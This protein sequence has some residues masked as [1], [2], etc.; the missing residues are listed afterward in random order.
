M[1]READLL[2]AHAAADAV[3]VEARRWTGRHLHR[4]SKPDGTL[5]TEADVAMEAVA[6]SVLSRFSR[7][8]AFVCEES[9]ASGHADRTWFVDALDGTTTFVAG[10]RGWSTVLALQEGDDI[11]LGMI[12]HPGLGARVWA[13]AGGGAWCRVGSRT[14]LLQVSSRTTLEGAAGF[15]PYWRFDGDPE[16]ARVL[17][18]LP[19][20][21]RQVTPDWRID[22]AVASAQVD[23][24]VFWG[25]GPWD[26]A[27]GVVIVEEAGGWFSDLCGGR[28][29]LRGRG[30]FATSAVRE[31]LERLLDWSAQP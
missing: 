17:G 20:L 14:S 6:V 27:A 31:D 23:L 19:R 3:E 22:A 16:V 15:L 2:S 7:G 8:D 5:V 25:A 9:G 11:V 18:D 24:A 13:T 28:S 21:I 4:A 30:L 29:L 1:G 12:N 10:L 26:L